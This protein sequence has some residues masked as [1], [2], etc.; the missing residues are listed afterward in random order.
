MDIKTKVATSMNEIS[1]LH[2]ALS[3]AYS[4]LS[5]ILGEAVTTTVVTPT[6]DAA[7]LTPVIVP[8]APVAPTVDIA[9]P[10]LTVAPIAP[11][12]PVI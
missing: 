11:V 3:E 12:A 5:G 6:V 1:L 9:S 10:I 4:G 2:K 7:P 8:N